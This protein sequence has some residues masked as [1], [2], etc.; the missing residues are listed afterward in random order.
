VLT[1]WLPYIA[2]AYVAEPAVEKAVDAA[3]IADFL[4]GRK[5]RAVV[6][7]SPSQ[8]LENLCRSWPEAPLAI[9]AGSLYLVAELRELLLP[10]KEV[11]S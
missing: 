1:P 6:C 2:E 3:D 8:A 9:V 4:R 10:E 5:C 11:L 7:G